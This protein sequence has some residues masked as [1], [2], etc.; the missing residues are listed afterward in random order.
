[1]KQWNVY[2]EKY[3]SNKIYHKTVSRYKLVINDE[4]I[5]YY[6]ILM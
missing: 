2:A 5:Y 3:Q 6:I 4:N 1:M